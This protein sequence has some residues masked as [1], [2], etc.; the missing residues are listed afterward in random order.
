[1]RGPVCFYQHCLRRSKTLLVLSALA[2][3]GCTKEK[4]PPPAPPAPVAA[5]PTGPTGFVEGTISARGKLPVFKA[6]PLDSSLHKQCGTEAPD[7]SLT[8]SADGALADAVVSIADAAPMP[9]PA[10]FQPAV[11]DQKSCV[12]RP[13]VV[14][15]RAGQSL[16][17]KNSDPLMHN[18]RAMADKTAIFNVAMPIENTTIDNPTPA[19][20]G[21]V[22]LHCDVHPWM[23]A[24]VATFAHDLYAVTKP[25]GSFRI[26]RVPVGKHPLKL[27][28]PRLGER[29]VEIEVSADKGTTVAAGWDI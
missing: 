13:A 22:R 2:F 16:K 18:V 24:W 5:A 9:L 23:T 8:V 25:D 12:Y 28:H 1:M 19:T 26:D 21:I 10:G 3:G 14:A 7:V 20:P 11:M 15:T 29:T 6:Q 4:P 17:V 27:W